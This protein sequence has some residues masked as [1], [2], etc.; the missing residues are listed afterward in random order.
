MATSEVK[1]EA[2]L[3]AV[4]GDQE[5]RIGVPRY[6]TQEGIEPFDAVEWESRTAYDPGQGRTVVR[7][8]GRRV[9]HV[10]EP[11]RH[12]HRRPEVFPR[13]AEHARP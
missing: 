7:A 12:E 9:P 4:D 3:P 10:L 11:D 2:E 8:E 13:Q 1:R 6:F 5:A